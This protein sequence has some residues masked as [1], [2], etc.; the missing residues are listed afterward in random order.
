M[1]KV[2][3]INGIK[4]SE[5]GMTDRELENKLD[6]DERRE[7]IKAEL[8]KSGDQR[9]EHKR[10]AA[11]IRKVRSVLNKLCKIERR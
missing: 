6:R 8:A 10:K 2:G 3:N 5:R 4:T 1:R 7:L 11:S 9:S